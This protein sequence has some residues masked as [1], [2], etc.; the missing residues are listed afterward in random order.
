MSRTFLM[1]PPEYF[2]VAYVINPWMHGNM[3]NIDNRLAKKQW[4]GLYDLIRQQARVQQLG[5]G[6][7]SLITQRS[8]IRIGHHRH[9][10]GLFR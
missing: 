8:E 2:D 5:G 1:C 4:R 7:G 9:H 10:R 6:Q 3:R